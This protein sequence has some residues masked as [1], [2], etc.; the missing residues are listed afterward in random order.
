MAEAEGRREKD[1]DLVEEFETVRAVTSDGRSVRIPKS[2]IGGNLETATETVLGGIK[3]AAKTEKETVEAKI[4]PTT[5]KLFVPKGGSEP[6][7]EDITLA[8]IEGEE[9]LQFKDKLYNASI[10][11]GLGRKYLRKNMVNEVNV[12]TQDFFTNEDGTE[13]TNTRYIIQYDYDLNGATLTIPEGCVLDFQGGSFSNGK[14]KGNLTLIEAP[15]VKILGEDLIT[16]GSWNLDKIN[17]EWFGAVGNGNSDSST[18]VKNAIRFHNNNNRT[19]FVHGPYDHHRHTTIQFNQGVYRINQSVVYNTG[20]TFKGENSLIVSDLGVETPVFDSGYLVDGN[21]ISNSSL[22][23]QELISKG[24][25]IGVHFEDLSFENINNCINNRGVVWQS[26]VRNCYF[27]FCGIAIQGDNNFY[28]QYRDITIYGTK[29]GNFNNIGKIILGE[30]ANRIQFQNVQI[31]SIA[32]ENNNTRG[33]GIQITD[34]GTNISIKDCSFELMYT[35]VELT[36]SITALSIEDIYTEAIQYL[37]RDTDGAVKE[38]L[39]I[40]GIYLYDCACII[41]ASGLR[42]SVIYSSTDGKNATY[43]GRIELYE[44]D[45]SNKAAIYVDDNLI[46]GVDELAVRFKVYGNIQ[47]IGPNA[48]NFIY[49]PIKTETNTISLNTPSFNNTT[50]DYSVNTLVYKKID[51]NLVLL[52]IRCKYTNANGSGVL[53]ITFNG[54]SKPSFDESEFYLLELVKH[55]GYSGENLIVYKEPGYEVFYIRSGTSNLDIQP[56]GE[57]IIQGIYS[58]V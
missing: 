8:E 23:T 3:A 1:L 36:G 9:K 53:K 46:K 16:D 19:T 27:N 55:D 35:G 32:Y 4:D 31:G 58:C 2:K 20:I 11:S 52:K 50:C 39:F 17:V 49:N 40:K 38:N 25:C 28:F 44:G 24:L 57:I 5:G 21:L 43:A 45:N 26:M 37:C 18:A 42:N 41:K 14:I 56:N 51:E 15:L 48:K 13:K 30:A 54:S 33:V 22:S 6:D 12:L 47:Y 34:G 7:D 29:N 10:Y